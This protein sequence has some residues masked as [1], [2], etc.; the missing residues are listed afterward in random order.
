LAGLNAARLIQGLA[1][2]I[3]PP[4]TV[5]GSLCWYVTHCEA[6]GFQ[7]MK[8]NFGLLPPL[9][10]PVR[11]KQQRYRAYAARAQQDLETFISTH[12]FEAASLPAST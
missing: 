7:P 12:N 3:L 9:D 10:P 2:L 11:H 6:D 8:A 1:P 4:T 5:M